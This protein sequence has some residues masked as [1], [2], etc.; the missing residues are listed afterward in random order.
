MGSTVVCGTNVRHFTEPVW[1]KAHCEGLVARGAGLIPFRTCYKKPRF[2]NRLRR[3]RR[4]IISSL[5]EGE[6]RAVALVG[7][8]P[9]ISKTRT[10]P[11]PVAD[12]APSRVIDRSESGLGERTSGAAG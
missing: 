8:G 9:S 3:S 11:P 1:E 4:R 6:A 5:G 7:N 12:V 2:C 10:H